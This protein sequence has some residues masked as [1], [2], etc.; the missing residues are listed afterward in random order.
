MTMIVW[1]WDNI[2]RFF[3]FCNLSAGWL[4]NRLWDVGRQSRHVVIVVSGTLHG[5]FLCRKDFPQQG[6]GAKRQWD[7]E[8]ISRM[9][10]GQARS[11]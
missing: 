9:L 2:I 7:H 6:R 3:F 5:A 1:D 10:K 8:A 4:G 11:V